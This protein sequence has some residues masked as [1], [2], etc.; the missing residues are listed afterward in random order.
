MYFRQQTTVLLEDINNFSDIYRIKWK[1]ITIPKSLQQYLN[2][3]IGDAVI[4]RKNLL[5]RPIVCVVCGTSPIEDDG[6]IVRVSR[7]ITKRL[8]IEIGQPVLIEK[9]DVVSAEIVTIEWYYHQLPKKFMDNCLQEI[10]NQQLRDSL[11][12]ELADL[13]LMEHDRFSTIL[14]IDSEICQSYKIVYWIRAVRPQFPVVR[15]NPETKLVTF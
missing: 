5:S 13:P 4:L 15:L 2:V 9:I 14:S 7:E 12:F 1:Q 6:N 11:F 10:I 8:R 3:K